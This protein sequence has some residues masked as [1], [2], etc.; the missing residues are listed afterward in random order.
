M[1]QTVSTAVTTNINSKAV[2]Y[3]TKLEYSTENVD[4]LNSMFS[5]ISGD[6]KSIY[7][8]DM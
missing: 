1:N 3:C 4:F 7:F 2:I 8:E 6:F 5:S